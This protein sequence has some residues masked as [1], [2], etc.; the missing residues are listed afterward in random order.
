MTSSGQSR[1]KGKESTEEAEGDKGGGP[2][3]DAWDIS[4]FEESPPDDAQESEF[5]HCNWF[6]DVNWRMIINPPPGRQSGKT[7]AFVFKIKGQA[8][9]RTV[10]KKD[11]REEVLKIGGF[12]FNYKLYRTQKSKMHFPKSKKHVMQ[13]N[14]S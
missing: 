9:K 10:G 3:K 13:G 5:Q 6:I 4:A 12:F 2:P 7:K 8:A 14:V 11:D 1:D